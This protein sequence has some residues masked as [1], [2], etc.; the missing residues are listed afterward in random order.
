VPTSLDLPPAAPIS[1]HRR[2]VA[3]LPLDVAASLALSRTPTTMVVARDGGVSW[4]KMGALDGGDVEQAMAAARQLASR[5]A[6][7]AARE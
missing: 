7:R 3:F 2:E 6:I 1:G 4:S 5:E